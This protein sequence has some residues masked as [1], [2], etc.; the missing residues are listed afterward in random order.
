MF[1]KRFLRVLIYNLLFGLGICLI[2][3]VPV[4]SYY[5]A[6][7]FPTTGQLSVVQN[8]PFS[9]ST[10]NSS[11]YADLA[12]FYQTQSTS[13]LNP[14]MQLGTNSLIYRDPLSQAY[15]NTMNYSNIFGVS[16]QQGQGLYAD[17]FYMTGG[18]YLN[19]T[20]P[21]TGLSFDQAFA[22]SPFGGS[23]HVSSSLVMPWASYGT[24]ID[25]V[26]AAGLTATL[27][28]V[29]PSSSSGLSIS[30][31]A[32]GTPT[33]FNL[34]GLHPDVAGQLAVHAYSP[35]TSALNM[36]LRD[37]YM[38]TEQGMPFIANA[39]Y[40]NPDSYGGSNWYFPAKLSYLETGSET[41]GGASSGYAISQS[42][43]GGS[44]Y[45]PSY[46][47]FSSGSWTGSLAGSNIVSGGWGG[48]F[49]GGSWTTSA[50]TSM[51]AW[52]SYAGP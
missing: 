49:P 48:G 4:F 6:G 39:S 42:I 45:F 43:S 16:L 22:Q 19:Y 51:S 28:G 15:A 40:Y 29:M 23:T 36:Y 17:P 8:T 20:S 24:S 47:G 3:S 9:S 38:Y 30:H 13:L 35:E 1:K 44:A 46:P 10:L 34:T 37:N 12:T 18:K 21:N 33:V 5:G 50:G 52:P 32:Y 25:T 2:S 7:I 11:L 14:F 27:F 26:H 41:V 31:A